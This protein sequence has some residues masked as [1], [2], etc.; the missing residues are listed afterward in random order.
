MLTTTAA[1][2]GGSSPAALWFRLFVC[3]GCVFC[4]A[5]WRVRAKLVALLYY[6][7]CF[8]L[9][10]FLLACRVIIS[11]TGGPC[12]YPGLVHQHVQQSWLH[13]PTAAAAYGQQ[14]AL[15]LWAH[16]LA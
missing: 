3:S 4:P 8:L 6:C 13:T 7:C 2:C 16:L 15:A 10:S 9:A 12:G 1:S 14:C 5:A 11:R